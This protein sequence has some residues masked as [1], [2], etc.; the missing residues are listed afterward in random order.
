L[1]LAAYNAGPGAVRKYGGIPPYHETRAYV[2]SIRHVLQQ[3]NSP[4][5]LLRPGKEECRNVW[6]EGIGRFLRVENE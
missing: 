4:E 5:A 2:R 6:C 3:T 1:M